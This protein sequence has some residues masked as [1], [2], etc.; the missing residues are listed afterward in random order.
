MTGTPPETLPR[1][2]AFAKSSGMPSTLFPTT[3]VRGPV[4]GAALDGMS[5]RDFRSAWCTFCAATKSKLSP[6][7]TVGG[8]RGTGGRG[9]DRPSNFRIQRPAL[10][11]AADPARSPDNGGVCA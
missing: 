7:L 3:R 8:A 11:A 5:S 2:M 4:M 9:S 6:S 10:R 1:R